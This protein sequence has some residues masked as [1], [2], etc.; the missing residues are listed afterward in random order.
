MVDTTHKQNFVLSRKDQPMSATFL[1]W[2]SALVLMA[3]VAIFL[4][5]S[6]SATDS[7]TPF[8][9][10]GESVVL[11]EPSNQK[12]VYSKNADQRRSMASTTKIMTALV[13]IENSNLSDEVT[14]TAESVGIEGTSVGLKQGETVSMRDLIY[15][16]MLESANDAASAIAVAVGGSIQGFAKMMNERAQS[17]EM[18][19]TNFQNPHGLSDEEHYTTASDLA[20]LAAAALENPTFSEIVS[21]KNYTVK[22]HNDEVSFTASNHNKLLRMYDGAIGVKT[23]FTKK[24]G[25]CLVGAATRNG[26]TL[27]CVTLNAPDDWN[28]HMKLFDYGFSQFC[29]IELA[30]VGEYCYSIPIIG[31]IYEEIKCMNTETLSIVLPNDHGEIEK[32]V[33][34]NRFLVAPV[35]RGKE[36]GKVSFKIGSK[37]I[38]ELPIVVSRDVFSVN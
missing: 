6:I 24:S 16:M 23:G 21:T 38:A 34:I 32:S 3:F 29:S 31:G 36:V 1:K 26:V 37:T 30:S 33:Y 22:L 4:T 28:D 11:Y 17:L 5:S 8:S 18:K 7:S 25:R 20:L 27:I 2:L 13:A 14:V 19:N 15:L 10:S 9:V 35:V 12:F